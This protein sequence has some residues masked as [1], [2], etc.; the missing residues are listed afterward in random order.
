MTESAIEQRLRRF[1]TKRKS[2]IAPCGDEILKRWN[3]DGRTD[4]ISMFKKANLDKAG[5]CYIKYACTYH[6][7]PAGRT[8]APSSDP[9]AGG[10]FQDSPGQMRMVY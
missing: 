10:N 2:G 6:R 9:G 1:C 8:E 7:P 4:L 5:K 3:G